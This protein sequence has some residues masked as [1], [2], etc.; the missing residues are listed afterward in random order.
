MTSCPH[1]RHGNCRLLSRSVTA[2]TERGR[3]ET[4]NQSPVSWSRVNSQP[5]RDREEEG[6]EIKLNVNVIFI[7]IAIK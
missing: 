6:P 7:F 2:E 4:V 5:I 3:G 1:L